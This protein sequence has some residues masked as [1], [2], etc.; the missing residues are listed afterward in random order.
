MRVQSSLAI[1]GFASLSFRYR[2]TQAYFHNAV[3]SYCELLQVVFHRKLHSVS[4]VFHPRNCS[5][6]FLS[7]LCAIVSKSVTDFIV[8]RLLFQMKRL[9]HENLNEFIGVCPNPDN[10]CI[11]TAYCMKGSLEVEL[12]FAFCFKC[13]RSLSVVCGQLHGVYRS[14]SLYQ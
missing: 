10:F 9:Q 13:V 2:P 6:E 7:Y 11:L 8:R 3:N 14:G 12:Y 1:N 5:V 4:F